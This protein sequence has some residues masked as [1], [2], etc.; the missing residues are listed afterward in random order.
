[1]DK[2]SKSSI[3]RAPRSLFLPCSTALNIRLEVAM[4][5]LPGRR[6]GPFCQTEWH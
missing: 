2:L 4:V 3:A 5:A 6:G 1:M